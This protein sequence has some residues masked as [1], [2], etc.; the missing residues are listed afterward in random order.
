M[1][2]VRI[3]RAGAERLA[4]IEPLWKG[5]QEHHAAVAPTLGGLEARTPEE[6][7]ERRRVKYELWLDDPDAFLLLAER[8]GRAVGYALV[9]LGEG[10]QGWAAGERVADV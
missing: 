2:D 6:A 9:T 4:D 8:D 5:L 1:N 10:S 7:W 3:V